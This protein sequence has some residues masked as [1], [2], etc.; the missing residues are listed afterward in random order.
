MSYIESSLELYTNSNSSFIESDLTPIENNDNIFQKLKKDFIDETDI[1]KKN[2][3]YCNSLNVIQQNAILLNNAMIETHL[4]DKRI[5]ELEEENLDLKNKL[6]GY[7]IIKNTD[8]APD[9][10]LN[11]LVCIKPK[12]SSEY[13]KRK[14]EEWSRP[15]IEM[16][17]RE[18]LLLKRKSRQSSQ[19]QQK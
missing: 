19:L 14:L 16:I 1:N 13:Y 17:V 3:N 15:D 7:D 11:S 8:V 12:M 9:D 5:D 6:E 10:L 18:N 4:K 2:E